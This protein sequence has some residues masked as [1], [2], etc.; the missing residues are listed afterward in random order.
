MT[1]EPTP[2]R[3]LGQQLLVPALPE[4]FGA[5]EFVAATIATQQALEAELGYSV[6]SGPVVAKALAIA[7]DRDTRGAAPEAWPL[8][9]AVE[10]DIEVAVLAT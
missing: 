8:V 9:F 3:L 7:K 1:H 5:H 2:L 6:A 10:S 4:R